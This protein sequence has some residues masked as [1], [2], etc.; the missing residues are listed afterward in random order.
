MSNPIAPPMNGDD[1]L[2]RSN[3]HVKP[4]LK[5]RVNIL[6]QRAK[7]SLN[8]KHQ[9]E[10]ERDTSLM[11]QNCHTPTDVSQQSK[12]SRGTND[13]RRPEVSNGETLRQPKNVVPDISK[14]QVSSPPTENPES[15]VKSVSHDILQK[16]DKPI[17]A[18]QLN[19]STASQKSSIVYKEVEKELA[20]QKTS[21]LSK[22][23]FTQV[24]NMVISGKGECWAQKLEDEAEFTQMMRELGAEQD[25]MSREKA[26]KV[27]PVI[28]G[29]IACQYY[30]IWH[31][32]SIVSLNP[33]VVHYMDYGNDEVLAN[34]DIRPLGTFEKI[35]PYARKIRVLNAKG[36]KYELLKESEQL[37]VKEISED[38]DG[39]FLVVTPDLEG[40]S[41]FQ[42]FKSR[43]DSQ[44]GPSSQ[45]EESPQDKRE[46]KEPRSQSSTKA[47]SHDSNKEQGK[48]TDEALEKVSPTPTGC[49]IDH[50]KAKDSGMMEI[51]T[52][53][54]KDMYS[55]TIVPQKLHDYYEK[56]VMEVP[57]KCIEKAKT[58]NYQ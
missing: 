43:A 22:D 6:N 4:E 34:D 53:L 57:A 35:P 28:G 2:Q 18:P 14:L 26:P 37:S 30:E 27:T 16:Q 23:K 49:V 47:P 24:I 25:S 33:L 40:E 44:N 54:K 3:I 52:P 7:E 36:T 13:I 55:V 29:L 1:Q 56:V 9:E 38:A 32:A 17:K 15:D 8:L 19:K 12:I 41:P 58:T 31:R 21:F 50:L 48:K 39:V 42:C 10:K 46:S 11:T 45:N 20:C 5:E 51:H